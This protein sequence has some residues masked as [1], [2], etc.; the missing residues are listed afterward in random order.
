MTTHVLWSVAFVL[1]TLVGRATP[2]L[3]QCAMCGN[4]FGQ[5][6]PTIGAFN[7]S[8]LFLMIAPYT[9]FLAAAL[10]VA[11]LHRRGTAGRRGRL[12]HFSRRPATLPVDPK[13]VTP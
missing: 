11:L 7:S 13:E 8:V 9:V 4:S 10:C 6:D 12:I 5:N 2:V 3:A 1:F